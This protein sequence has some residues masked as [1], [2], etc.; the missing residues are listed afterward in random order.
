MKN[1]RTLFIVAGVIVAVVTLFF[2][3]NFIRENR[4]IRNSVEYVKEMDAELIEGLRESHYYVSDIV[5]Y[6]RSTKTIVVT[7]R[8]D[9]LDEIMDYG[10]STELAETRGITRHMANTYHEAIKNKFG[11]DV[12]VKIRFVDA[13]SGNVYTE[14]T[15]DEYVEKTSNEYTEETYDEYI[16]ETYD[17]YT[18]EIYDDYTEEAFDE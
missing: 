17:D 5:S 18:E 14:E 1:K 10:N 3:A 12:S 11:I 4:D 13:F 15:S 6:D 7:L 9:A 16:E 2:V 8:V